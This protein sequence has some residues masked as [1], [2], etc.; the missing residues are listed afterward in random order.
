VAI[1]VIPVCLIY[2]SGWPGDS[3]EADKAFAELITTARGV[4]F[5]V[6]IDQ[7]LLAR[8][9]HFNMFEILELY[10]EPLVCGKGYYLSDTNR[11]GFSF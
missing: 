1:Y 2:S 3:R 11:A 6:G 7:H 10:P 8:N 4:W 5:P 9:R